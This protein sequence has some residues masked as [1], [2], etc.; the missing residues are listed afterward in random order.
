MFHDSAGRT[1][2]DCL[3]AARAGGIVVFHGIAAGD[4]GPVDPRLLMDRSLILTGG[5]LW[6]VPTNAAARRERADALFA[7]IRAGT[8]RPT[9]A[10][11]FPP[12]DGARAHACLEGRRAIGKVLPTLWGAPPAGNGVRTQDASA[13]SSSKPV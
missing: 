10:A 12:G 5:D 7:Q 13:R 6:N 1:R 3:A 2:G 8:V 4:P 11:R 9:V